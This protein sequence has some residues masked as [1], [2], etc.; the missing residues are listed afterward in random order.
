[1]A[2]GAG[3][4]FVVNLST[5]EYMVADHYALVERGMPDGYEKASDVGDQEWL[6]AIARAAGEGPTELPEREDD[7]D[8]VVNLSNGDSRTQHKAY[9][10]DYGVEVGWHDMD[11]VGPLQY[12]DALRDLYGME[13][14]DR[15]ELGGARED[16]GTAFQP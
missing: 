13:P 7:E 10:R 15:A 9:T 4:V 6:D 2:L 12:L 1:M 16:S 5:G 8:V 14:C 3:E 11:C